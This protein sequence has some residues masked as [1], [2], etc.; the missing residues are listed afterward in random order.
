MERHHY[1]LPCPIHKLMRRIRL[2]EHLLYGEGFPDAGSASEGAAC[3][4][5]TRHHADL[6][7][8]NSEL[9]PDWVGV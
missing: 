2:R 3:D 4:L 5:P 9:M 7:G 8:C 1:G 6:F